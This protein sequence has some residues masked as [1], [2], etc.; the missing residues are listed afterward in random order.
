MSVID[1]YRAA[2]PGAEPRSDWYRDGMWDGLLTVPP[3]PQLRFVRDAEEVKSLALLP[4]LLRDEFDGTYTVFVSG[5]DDFR[6][7]GKQLTGPL[8]A[9]R[10]SRHG[11]LIRCCR[12]SSNEAAA[13]IV[14]SWWP[15]AGRNIAAA[16]LTACGENL[17][18]AWYAADKAR[19]AGYEPD[20]KYIPFVCTRGS[21][22]YADRL[23]AGQRR[24]AMNAART[25]S[26]EEQG[27]VIGML[28]YKMSLMPLVRESVQRRESMADLASRMRVGNPWVLTQLRSYAAQYEPDRVARCRTV[29]AIAETAWKAG[30][31]DGILEAV[32]A[33]WLTCLCIRAMS[34]ERDPVTDQKLPEPGK[35]AIHQA[36]IDEL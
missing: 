27:G 35:V 11:Q 14:A 36:V 9:L 28:A 12:P 29:L 31:R 32:A 10:D 23:L 20:H 26:A 25:V 6:R 22:A 8:A 24:E 15:G 18:D 1:A 3:G 34:T 33:L 13:D 16:L 4:D 17:L 19:R 21:Q 2:L 7:E 5:E 30:A